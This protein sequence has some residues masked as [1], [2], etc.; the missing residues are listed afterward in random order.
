[1]AKEFEIKEAKHRSILRPAILYERPTVKKLERGEYHN[2]KIRTVSGD[3]ESPI[4]EL[5]VPFFSAGTPEE[6]IKFHK[7][8]KQVFVGQDVTTGPTQYPL[9]RSI[10]QGDALTMFDASATTHWPQTVDHFRLIMADICQHVFPAKA[11]KTQKRYMQRYSKMPLG[12]TTKE[13]VARIQEMN[14]YLVLF[15]T[16][17]GIAPTK[18][19]QEDFMDVLEYSL[20]VCWCQEMTRQNFHPTDES[21]KSFVDLRT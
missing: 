3:A 7:N 20:P 6:W 18:F 2:Y 4:Y 19:S 15:P 12:T 9:A 17:I 21:V 14:D 1:M 16:T 11:V 5:S 10:L 8:V 13:F